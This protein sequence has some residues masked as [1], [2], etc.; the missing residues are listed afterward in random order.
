MENVTGGRTICG[1]TRHG[2][3]VRID[4]GHLLNGHGG[5]GEVESDARA[6]LTVAVEH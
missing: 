5:I 1:V 4:V 2:I 3:A 6:H